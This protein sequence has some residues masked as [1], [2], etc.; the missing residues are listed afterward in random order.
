MLLG[1]S[2]PRGPR[3]LLGGALLLLV[4]CAAGQSAPSDRGVLPPPPDAP[5]IQFADTLGPCLPGRPGC[6]TPDGSAPRDGLGSDGDARATD[7]PRRDGPRT[8]GPRRDSRPAD[9]RRPDARPPD[10]RL[11]DAAPKPCELTE[12]SAARWLGS[13]TGPTGCSTAFS[14][15]PGTVKVGTSSLR[16]ACTQCGFDNTARLAAP[17]G[18]WNLKSYAY[19][20]FWA[21]SQVPSSLG[22]QNGAN[23]NNP[24]LVLRDAAGNSRRSEPADGTFDFNTSRTQWVQ[25]QLPLA[26]AA[27]YKVTDAG[28]FD[29]S[30]VVSLELHVDP[31]DFGFTLWLDGLAF[32][33]GVFSQCP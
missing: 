10:A 26:P 7:G 9:S 1:A 25:L 14:D 21:R 12:G 31:W 8:D 32:G 30:R 28:A 2:R 15:D 24:W 22:W 6:P 5:G 29:L 19:A 13:C 17:A 33:P 16:F 20:T 23:G 11:P 18:G 3:P 27:N 4:G